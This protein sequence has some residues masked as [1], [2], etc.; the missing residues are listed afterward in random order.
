MNLFRRILTHRHGRF[1]AILT[2]GLVLSSLLSINAE[3]QEGKTVKSVD[4]QYVGYQTVSK[5]RILSSTSSQV[6]DKL[7]LSAV[8]EDVKN[9]YKSGDVEN[10]KVLANEVGGGIELIFVVQTRAVYGGSQFTG[11]TVVDTSKLKRQV[12]LTVNDPID[13]ELLKTARQDIQ[14]L[15]R[16]K[17]FSEAT[18]SYRIG[19]PTAEGYSTVVFA[20]DEGIQGVIRNV[21]FVGNTAFASARLK[22]QMTQ[23]EKGLRSIFGEA[24]AVDAETLAQDVRAIEDFYRDNGYL[25]AKV[26]NVS[27]LRADAKYV[28][29]IMTIEEGDTYLVESLVVN[30]VSALSMQDD[31]VPYLRTKAGDKFAGG[32]LKSDIK[33]IVD[34]YGSR[35]YADARVVPRLEDAGNGA[36]KVV[37]NISEGRSYRIGQINIEGNDKTKDHVIRRELPLEPGQPFDTT[38]TE[39]TQRR[40]ENM[41][42]FANVELLPLDASYLDEKDLLIRVVEKPTGSIN[43][44]AGFS[45]ID[46]LTGFFEVTQSNFDLFDPWKF[47]GG[48]QRFR[49]SA[50]A[51]SERQDYSIAITEPWAFGRPIA[52][53]AEAYYRD[54][55]FV[56]DQYD[57]TDIGAAISLRKSVGEFTYASVEFRGENIEITPESNASPA[58]LNEKGDFMKSSVG[59]TIVRDT[60]DNVFLPRLGSKVSAGFEF[61]GLGGDIDDNIFTLQGSKYFNLPYDAIVSFIGRYQHSSNGD[62]LF[63]RHFLGG[64]NNL[65]GFDFRDVGPRDQVSGES[66]GGNEAWYGTAELTLPIVEK[67]RGALFYDIGEVSGGPTGS[68]GGGINSD[69]GVGVRMFILGSAPVRLDYAFPLQADAFNDEGGRFQFTMGAQF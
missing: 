10:V 15:Y 63:T 57:Q 44:G 54:L 58:F 45:S 67:I 65:R 38:K 68:V 26:T 2:A 11:N 18:V 19:A 55:L 53:T 28:D 46:S 66:L 36:V 60:R 39:V 30:G 14:K 17:G 43:F 48:G 7:S 21:E 3:A 35:G 41:N 52:L 62:H 61:V 51:G 25:N 16:K 37:I 9:L 29:V 34:Q 32:S 59:L 50:R 12:D 49:F 13:E 27:R 6:G 5:A 64:A 33:L 1:A 47:S 56:S 40:L 22:D 31:I 24:G 42:Y 8:D 69:W 4:V 23:K 20:I